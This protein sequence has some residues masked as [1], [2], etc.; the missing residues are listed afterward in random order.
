M[1]NT[2]KTANTDGHLNGTHRGMLRGYDFESD[3]GSIKF[4]IADG[5]IRGMVTATA[6]VAGHSVQL[7]LGE[8]S[9]MDLG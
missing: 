5:G 8:D 4:E 9:G 1:T 3:D 7:K 6:V 2:I